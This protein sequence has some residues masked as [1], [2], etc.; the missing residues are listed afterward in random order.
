V[1]LVPVAMTLDRWL[2]RH[3]RHQRGH[4]D[5]NPSQRR[6]RRHKLRTL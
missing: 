4:D 2:R 5:F 6:K 3:Q 1:P